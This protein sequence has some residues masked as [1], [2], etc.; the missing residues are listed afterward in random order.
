[1]CS[2][3]VLLYGI[4]KVVIGEN[5]TFRGPEDYVRSR[6]VELEIRNDAECIRL[7]REFIRA[8]P[9]LWNEDIGE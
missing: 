7:M 3:T 6:G 4:P 9:E 5:T 8:K 2:G 1:M